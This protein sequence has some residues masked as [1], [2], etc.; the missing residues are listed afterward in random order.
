MKKTL[1]E[2]GVKYGTDKSDVIHSY[3]GISYLDIYDKHFF[4][5]RNEVEVVVE[6]GVLNGKSL[7]MWQEYFPNAIIYG[8]DIDPRC[9]E[10]ENDRIKIL[11]GDQNDK[12]FLNYVKDTI[13]EYDIL[14]DDGSHINTHQIL[15]FNVL[16]DSLS[17]GGYYVIEDLRMSYG[18]VINNIDL[19]K[20]WPGMAYNNINDPLKNDRTDFNN[21]LE[22]KIKELDFHKNTCNL[23]AIHNYPMIVIFE[24][25]K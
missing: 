6:I 22:S 18:E 4:N 17:R 15:T 8:I 11:I 21:F 5:I 7:L 14:I 13:G 1:Q 25:L 23:L 2:L 9:K 12:K 3:N 19:R 16:Y 24:N 20:Y 10:Y